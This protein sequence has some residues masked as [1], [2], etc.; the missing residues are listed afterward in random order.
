MTFRKQ[1][2]SLYWTFIVVVLTILPGGYF[3]SVPHFMDLFSPDKITHLLIFGTLCFLTIL[4]L[5]KQYKR[6]YLRYHKIKIA[7]TYSFILGAITEIL[8]SEMNWGR[9]GSIYDF[10]A[11]ITG[12]LLGILLYKKIYKKFE[13]KQTQC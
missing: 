12:G 6:P 1:L 7:F 13:K 10:I 4:D 2:F 11:N 5:D 3:P 9:Q 8:Q